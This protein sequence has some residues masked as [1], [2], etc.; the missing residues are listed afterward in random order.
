MDA[1]IK[2][3]SSKINMLVGK[4]PVFMKPHFGSLLPSYRRWQTTALRN[5]VDLF[6]FKFTFYG[7]LHRIALHLG[8][9]FLKIRWNCDSVHSNHQNKVQL[10]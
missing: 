9:P 7:A 6:S 4:R 3:D 5:F 1:G 10:A 2:C 8:V